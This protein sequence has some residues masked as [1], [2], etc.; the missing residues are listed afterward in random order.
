MSAY[1]IKLVSTSDGK[2]LHIYCLPEVKDFS[3]PE[4][5]STRKPVS[6]F[7]DK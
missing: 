4:V 2:L 6:L 7:N 5:S 3:C 1:F